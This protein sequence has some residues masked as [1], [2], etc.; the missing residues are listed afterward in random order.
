V[1]SYLQEV[2]IAQA[3]KLLKRRMTVTEVCEAVGFES[4]PTFTRLLKKN[5]R[6]YSIT[7]SKKAF[8]NK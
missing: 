8:L 4:I 7:I 2:R 6:D 5:H 3:K 1:N